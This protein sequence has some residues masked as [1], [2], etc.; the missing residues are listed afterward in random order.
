MLTNRLFTVFTLFNGVIGPSANAITYTSK[1]E[2]IA[3]RDKRNKVFHYQLRS[4]WK[5]DIVESIQQQ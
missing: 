4:P 1:V 2:A 3:E 5:A